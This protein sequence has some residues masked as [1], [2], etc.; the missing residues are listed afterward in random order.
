MPANHCRAYERPDGSTVVVHP[1]L[2]GYHEGEGVKAWLERVYAG[3]V[4]GMPELADLPY[5]DR[6]CTCL[7][8]AE[9]AA[10]AVDEAL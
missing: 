10:P 5:R 4:E 1:A 9:R 6:R 3:A 2:Q 8:E 7:D